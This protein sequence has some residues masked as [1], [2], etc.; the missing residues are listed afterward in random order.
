MI[1][2]YYEVACDTCESPDY[3]QGNLASVKKQAKA[4]GW[5]ITRDGKVYCDKD[6]QDD[7]E[8]N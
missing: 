3:L 5:I 2:K 7:D 6:C 1:K 4:L 8:R